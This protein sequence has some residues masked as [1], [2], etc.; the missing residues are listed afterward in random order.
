MSNSPTVTS[1]HIEASINE[2]LDHWLVQQWSELSRA[3]I[4]R[5]IVSGQVLVNDIV[6][7]PS[8]HPRSGDTISFNRQ[9]ALA[10]PPLI[11]S[12]PL[13]LDIVFEDE[14]LLVINKPAG[15]VVHPGAGHADGTLVQALLAYRP[16]L[17]QANLDPLR[18]GLV[19]RLDKDTSGLLVVAANLRAQTA[20]QAQFKAHTV[21][22]TYLAIL[23][24]HLQP[25]EGAIEAPIARHPTQRYKMAVTAVGGREARTAFRVREDFHTACYVEAHPLTG[26]THQIRVH[27]AAVGHAVVGDII[28]GPRHQ[29][30]AA[31]RQMLHAWRISFDHPLTGERLSLAIEP[32]DD[33]LKVLATLRLIEP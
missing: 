12:L 13:P 19:H 32:P 6:E 33:F 1:W 14:S 31:P 27:F 17:E 26:R 22:K 30:I 24:G 15:L 23:Y 3:Q 28:Y 8:Y 18:P 2:R 10:E 7:K 9:P 20:L 5:L 29:A 25:V 16:G 4:T 21:E 11:Q